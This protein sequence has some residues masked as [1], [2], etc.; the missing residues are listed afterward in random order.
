MFI[1]PYYL[2][3]FDQTDGRTPRPRCGRAE[4]PGNRCP[5]VHADGHGEHV[6]VS[7]RDEDVWV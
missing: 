3:N 4:S 7:D 2:P 1:I 5:S 6:G